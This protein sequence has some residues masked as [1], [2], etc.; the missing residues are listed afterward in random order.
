MAAVLA[1]VALM[2]WGVIPESDIRAPWVLIAA[3]LLPTAVA[4]GCRIAARAYRHANAFEDV[5]RQV[6]ADMNMLREASAS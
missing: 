4:L 3:P 6:K 5:M 1:G 2:L